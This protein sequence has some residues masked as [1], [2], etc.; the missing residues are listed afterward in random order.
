MIRL[1]LIGLLFYLIIWVVR[2][3]VRP[4][5]DP[6]GP[7]NA[8]ERELVMDALTGVWFSKKKAVTVTTGRETLYFSSLSNRDAWLRQHSE[9]Q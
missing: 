2:D 1:F 4:R 8:E 6:G 7:G 5:K 9:S 3:L